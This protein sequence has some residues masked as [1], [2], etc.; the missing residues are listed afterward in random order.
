MWAERTHIDDILINLLVG[1]TCE[2]RDFSA[3]HLASSRLLDICEKISKVRCVFYFSGC[4]LTPLSN[5][6]CEY[7]TVFLFEIQ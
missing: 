2:F 1:G 4:T 7:S 5:N 6:P 3:S